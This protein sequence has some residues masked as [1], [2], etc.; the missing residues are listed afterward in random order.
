M[1]PVQI[2]AVCLR[3]LAII[4]F[5][6]ILGH[7]YGLFAFWKVGGEEIISNGFIWFNVVLQLT[8]CLLLWFFPATIAR[9]LLPAAADSGETR[10][11]VSLVEW[12]VLGVICVGVW[13]LANA[14]PDA[15]YWLTFYGMSVGANYGTYDLGP[16]QKASTFS[17]LA[18]LAIGFWL[19]LGAKGF[20]A[21][22]FK[23]RTGGIS[24]E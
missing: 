14:V 22:L 4:W 9:K 13:T 6:Y 15:I 2:V 24:K 1:T 23:I 5:L 18:Q 19:V 20:A 7:S 16:D 21:L 8:M 12:Q 11:P 10:L 17:T 3:L